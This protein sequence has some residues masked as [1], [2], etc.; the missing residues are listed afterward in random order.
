M[1]AAR[2]YY[3]E[4][5]ITPYVHSYM[6]EA[7]INQIVVNNLG[8]T[9][10]TARS[11]SGLAKWRLPM[12]G[13]WN[14]AFDGLTVPNVLVGAAA[15]VRIE[16]TDYLGSEVVYAWATGHIMRAA[17]K[18]D[19][20]SAIDWDY[21]LVLSGAPTRGRNPW[22]GAMQAVVIWDGVHLS[23]T[24]E[25]QDMSPTWEL[26]DTGIT[27]A[28]YDGQSVL[29]S[30]DAVGMWLLT[31]TG[32][33]WCG[34]ILA[35][36]PV[37]VKQLAI[38]TVR[39][40]DAAIA[41]GNIVF[42][43]M[44]AY[45]GEPGYLIAATGPDN[46]SSSAAFGY[47]HSYTWHTHDYGQNWTQVDMAAFTVDFSGNVAG[48]CGCGRAG[49]DIHATLPIIWAV[50]TTP[51]LQDR[52]AVFKSLDLGSTWTQGYIIT[53]FSSGA[54]L[55]APAP[56]IDDRSYLQRG[57]N[58]SGTWGWIYTSDDGWG[59][60]TQ[61][62]KPTGYSGTDFYVRPA[63]HPL[64]PDHCLAL[65]RKTTGNA[66]V[67]ESTDGG[68]S[69]AELWDTGIVATR[70]NTP[71]AWPGDANSWLTVFK[72]KSLGGTGV[73]MYTGNHFGAVVNKEGNLAALLGSW[74]TGDGGGFGL[75]RLGANA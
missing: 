66:W 33:W 14:S 50:R 37:W 16:L 36:S 19:L 31:A 52:T 9:D 35:A 68:V 5:D 74:T 4:T 11:I 62:A 69:W 47:G 45:A 48:Y 43:A 22:A 12:Q 7:A 70:V 40:A 23:R 44:R 67:L 8:I 17:I 38:E 61:Q 42:Q 18:A 56:D 75:P 54:G 72:Q 51:G 58:L 30:G 13:W 27:G 39:A 41:E 28:I 57:N 32:V 55:L 26:I 71:V 73:V 3:N 20:R 2:I 60:A 10:N 15:P 53:D 65:W 63:S 59:T 46:L 24:W 49:I 1:W 34:D 29:L 21:E 64:T 6:L 25:I